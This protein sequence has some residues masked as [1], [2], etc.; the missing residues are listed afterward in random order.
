V[1]IGNPGEARL[2]RGHACVVEQDIE[3]SEAV[4]GLRKCRLHLI[5]M[6]DVGS[7]KHRARSLAFD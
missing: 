1:K 2:R 4:D 5:R 3:A 7:H 6:A